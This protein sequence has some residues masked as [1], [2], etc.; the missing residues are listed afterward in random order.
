M[1]IE[2][3][4]E[5]LSAL[6]LDLLELARVETDEHAFE[7]EPVDVGDILQQSVAAHQDVVRSK[8]LILTVQPP[9]DPVWGLADPGGIRTIADNLIDNAI[10]YTPQGGQVNVHWWHDSDG[11]SFEVSDTG[12]GIAKEHQ[13]RI[14]ERF[15]RV[16]RARS[17]EVGGTGLGLSIVKHL[18][19][20]FD[21]DI[22]VKSRLG[23]GS[24]FTVRLPAADPIAK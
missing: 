9:S 4:A 11:V 1:R 3:Q 17:R 15:F 16:D 14:F 19:Q 5:R 8:N 18:C 22:K 12:V 6:I 13:A 7:L 20:V 2:E 24:T 23:H 10:N 21:G